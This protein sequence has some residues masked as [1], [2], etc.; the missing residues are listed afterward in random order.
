M[1]LVRYKVRFMK[2]V[3][4][5]EAKAHLSE[6]LARVE[7]GETVIIARRNKPVARLVPAEPEQP[8]KKRPIGLAKGCGH[9]P[10]EFFDPLDD[11]LLDLFEGRTAH[12]GDPLNPADGN[13]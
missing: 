5:H 10:P 1:L 13:R 11:E 9:V 4:V 6:Y 2:M 8:K 3:N 7:A 12:P